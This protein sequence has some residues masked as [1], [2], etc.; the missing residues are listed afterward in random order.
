MSIES[1]IP[2]NHLILCRPLLLLPSI[3]PSIRVFSSE[4]ALHIR[5][6]EYWSFS[7]S[8]SSSNEYSGLISFWIDCLIFLQ[9][10]GL[11]RVFSSTRVRK[12]EF[13]SSHPSL[14][15]NSHIHTC[16]AAAAA[17]AKLLQL[18]LT[19]CDP[20]DGSPPGSPSLGF[21]RQEHWSGLPFPSPMHE[22]EK[23]KV[24]VK[25][26]SCVRLL[27]TPWTAAYQAPPSMGFSRQEYWSGVPLP[28]PHPYMTTGKTIALRIIPLSAKWC[29]RT[30][31]NL[32]L[33]LGVDCV[34][35]IIQRMGNCLQ[36]LK[37]YLWMEEFFYQLGIYSWKILLVE[38]KFRKGVEAT[39]RNRHQCPQK[40]KFH[41]WPAW[42]CPTVSFL[43]I[44]WDIIAGTVGS[45]PDSYFSFFIHQSNSGFVGYPVAMTCKE[46][47]PSPQSHWIG[48]V[49]PEYF[50]PFVVILLPWPA[51]GS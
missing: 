15:S 26:L 29:L 43:E 7:F 28:S 10:K 25:L 14:W 20:I 16:C 9:S 47:S 49:S 6:P 12:H 34:A 44:V 40:L 51:T 50:K 39:L 37:M 4:L 48:S 31:F 3:F 8:I 24:K 18:C 17:A 45:L 21:S 33:L 22:S 11:S 2:S 36:K 13:F 23:W 32:L 19:L 41:K 38:L 30:L 27:A 1:V 46:Y 42:S 5:W 35:R